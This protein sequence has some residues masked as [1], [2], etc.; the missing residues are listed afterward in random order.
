MSLL[1][2]HNVSIAFGGSPLLDSVSFE[3]QKGQRICL[4]GRNGVGKSTL[5]KII[6]GLNIPDSGE[7]IKDEGVRVAYLPQDVP[8]QISGTVYDI[9][10]K[11]AGHAGELLTQLRS[12]PASAQLHHLIEETNGWAVQN[13]IERVLSQTRLDGNADFSSLSGGIK[14]RV[15]L[16]RALVKEPD[17]LLL[18][19]PTNHLDIES[20][21]WLESFILNSRITV[22]F[23]THD[24]KLL[25][26]LATRIIELD[27]GKIFDWS[28]D[29]TTFLQRKQEMLDAEEKAWDLF[30][31]KL[32]Q[33]E[34]WVRRGIKARRTRNE[35]RV[36]S[37][38]RM[39]K[40][41][42][43]RRERSGTVNM[44][45]SE[46]QRSGTK[47]LEAHDISFY[48]GKKPIVN[49]LSI[50]IIRG[51]RIG[52]IGPNGSGKTTLINLLL[53][54]MEPQS[55]TVETGTSVKA[56]IFRSVPHSA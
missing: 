45:I 30:D 35:G 25:K 15:F 3:L 29:Y 12:N 18:D 16:A 5:M 28:C 52:I 27:R 1:S 2:L 51:D 54:K 22:F 50:T 46:A 24:R 43:M 4:L 44:S 56:S 38:L 23:V 49:D 20:I 9:V 8:E 47:V 48:Y 14:R 6:A 11:G 32:S 40:E 31:K 17:L 33:E 41:R 37:L 34:V 13:V 42:S 10:A 7:I 53:G 55:G 19:E 36:R 21:S 26:T 39:R